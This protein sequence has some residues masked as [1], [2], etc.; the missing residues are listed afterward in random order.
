MVEVG[1]VGDSEHFQNVR[2]HEVRTCEAVLAIRMDESLYFAN[3]KYLE[4][5]LIRAVADHPRANALLLIC[6]AIECG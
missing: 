5:S 1:R 3:T 2:R 6:S 4:D